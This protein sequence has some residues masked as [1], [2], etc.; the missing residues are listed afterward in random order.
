MVFFLLKVIIDYLHVLSALTNYVIILVVLTWTQRRNNVLVRGGLATLINYKLEISTLIF[1]FYNLYKSLYIL[2][3][4]IKLNY[5][6][7]TYFA[8]PILI[9]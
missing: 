1:I 8:S 4:P 7:I 5:I 9:F 3:P 2:A 6:T